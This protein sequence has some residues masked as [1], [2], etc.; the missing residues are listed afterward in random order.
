MRH[1]KIVAITFCCLFAWAVA[2]CGG[3]EIESD[4]ATQLG[5]FGDVQ[6]TTTFCSATD[7][8]GSEPAGCATYAADHHAQAVAGYRI[9]DGSSAPATFESTGD[10]ALT[11]T[12]DSGVTDYLEATYP[13]PGAKWVG[14]ESQPHDVRA[15][16]SPRWTVAPRFTVA[17][18]GEP[19]QYATVG[20]YREAG[21]DED[22]PMPCG[23]GRTGTLCDATGVDE[24][25]LQTRELVMSEGP[26]PGIHQNS[27]GEVPFKLKFTGEVPDGT[28]FDLTATT[29]LPGATVAP[30]AA[31]FRPESD[32]TSV[33]AAVV[34]VPG[35]AEPGG[36][37]VTLT[38]RARGTGETRSATTEFIV[39]PKP[40]AALSV[41]EWS[42][43]QNDVIGDLQIDTRLCTKADPPVIIT[44]VAVDAGCGASVA[45]QTT[46]SLLAY[47]IP[48]E[49]SAPA[50]LP[51][52]GDRG[53]D[54][55]RD[56]PYA[57]WLEANRPAPAGQRWVGYVS[58]A[59]TTPAGTT[60]HWSVEARFGLPT[61]GRPY[62]GPYPFAIAYGQRDLAGG[63]AA[64]HPV[65]CSARDTSCSQPLVGLAD[66]QPTRDLGVLPGGEPPVIA[67]GSSG[68]V[69]FDLL[70]AGAAG[71]G[72]EFDL[73][74][75]SDLDGAAPAVAPA[76]VPAADS[77]NPVGVGVEVPAGTAPGAYAVE[78][79]ARVG[80]QR[81]SGTMHFTVPGPAQAQ[82]EPAPPPVL[83][84]APL[85]PIPRVATERPELAVSLRAE[86]RR[87]YTGTRARY[88]LVARND[89]R[90]VTARRAHVC[91]LLPGKVQY[92]GASRRLRFEGRS[93][94]F[95]LGR[96][97]PGRSMVTRVHV[98]VNRDARPGAARARATVSAANA[99]SASARASLRVIRRAQAPRPAPVT[100]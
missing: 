32:S 63:G 22:G 1:R 78:L 96:L 50:S 10:I 88:R 93:V 36:Y 55:T 100:G 18:P 39:M 95:R 85:E 71:G 54:Y 87:A 16:D 80:E 62:S 31:S 76:L 19:F 60:E 4:S 79:T 48:A 53:G 67:S 49:S 35:N 15:G 34:N 12:Q 38:A 14:Y 61:P 45:A 20:G 11:Y 42:S 86:P 98:R 75:T 94:C 57:D 92:A 46:Q 6:V 77:H 81:R 47:R 27:P 23:E 25:T 17:T 84:A 30:K 89:A 66:D 58:A 7:S 3:I 37:T 56:A 74:A 41:E 90:A 21:A 44:K 8:S 97:R 40:G 83:P 70:F 24:H 13:T 68:T 5:V 64:G 73:E 69:P 29:D 91:Q 51:T 52:A 9:P 2:G 65:D 28:T 26:S 59:H 82:A 99:P 72:A 43:R 33:E